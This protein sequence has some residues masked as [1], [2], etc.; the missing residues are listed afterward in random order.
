M[1]GT[2]ETPSDP[3]RWTLVLTLAFLVLSLWRI[4]TPTAPM[5]DEVHYLPAARNLLDDWTWTNREHPMLGKQ[6]IALGIE[7]F[8]DT[9]WGWRVF[10]AVFGALALFAGMRAL[11][12]ASLS[13]FASLA[14]GVLLATGFHLFIHARIAMLDGFM[15]AL[16]LVALWQCAA[17]VR[18]PEKGRWRLALAGIALGLSMGTK[19]NVV[20]LAMLPGLAFFFARL[21]AGRRRLVS[22]RRGLPVPGVALWEAALLLG[23]LPLIAYWLTYWPAYLAPQDPL[24]PGGFIEMHRHMLELQESVKQPHPYQSQWPDWLL[25]RRAIWYLYENVDGAQRGVV[26]LGNPLTMLLGLPAMLWAGWVG[27]ARR[28][29]DTLAVALLFAFGLGMWIVANKP[30]QFYYHYF[31][32]SCFLLAALALALDEFWQRGW[33]WTALAAV[34][35]SML[36]FAYFYPILSAWPLAGEMAFTSWAWIEGWR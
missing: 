32:P 4:A 6:L 33:R 14:F 11:W 9:A 28:R 10:P 3:L 2:G 35:G 7:L 15:V 8:G 25:N 20:L 17:A 29:W 23:A 19:W 12:F 22:S 36:T 5:F 13:R 1:S 16:F 31:L 18:E 24:Q 34:G 21:S 27:V 30:I 26:L